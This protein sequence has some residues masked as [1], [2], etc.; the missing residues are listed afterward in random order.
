MPRSLYFYSIGGCI[1]EGRQEIFYLF[2]EN[3]IPAGRQGEIE[4]Q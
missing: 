3:F 4:M 2:H 1:N